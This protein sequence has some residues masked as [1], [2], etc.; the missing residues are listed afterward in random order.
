[1]PVQK[2]RKIVSEIEWLEQLVTKRVSFLLWPLYL[3]PRPLLRV[4]DY[5]FILQTSRKVAINS[6]LLLLQNL[7]EMRTGPGERRCTYSWCKGV[8]VR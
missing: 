8:A 6:I 3:C 5:G 7:R 4:Q 1:M 2:N